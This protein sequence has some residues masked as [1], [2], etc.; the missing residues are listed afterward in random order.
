M[1][2]VLYRLLQL[3]VHFACM[4]I[5]MSRGLISLYE[6]IQNSQVCIDNVSNID[7]GKLTAVF[8]CRFQGS[9]NTRMH[10][11]PVI[12]CSCNEELL[13]CIMQ[14]TGKHYCVY[15]AHSYT[16]IALLR[17]CSVQFSGRCF[18]HQFARASVGPSN[19]SSSAPHWRCRM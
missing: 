12:V 1:K 7:D 15:V 3:L 11:K 5:I 9:K 19:L 6:K 14:C 8:D 2:S 16:S 18:C 17:P 10:R 13:R 4:Y